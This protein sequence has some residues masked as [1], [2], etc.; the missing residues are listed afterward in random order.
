MATAWIFS[1]LLRVPKY[2]FNHHLSTAVSW[3]LLCLCLC[4]SESLSSQLR[5]CTS[6]VKNDRSLERVQAVSSKNGKLHVIEERQD[7]E[8]HWLRYSLDSLKEIGNSAISFPANDLLLEHFF[9]VNDTLTMVYS[10]WNKTA[11]RTDVFAAR[12]TEFGSLVDSL[13]SVHMRPENGKPRRSGL[14]CELS[15]D[16]TKFVLFFDGEVE[17]KQSEGIHF[18]CFNRSL[19]Q[20]W[21]KELRLPPAVEIAQVHHYL[22]DNSGAIYLMSGRNPIKSFSDWQRPQG[23]QYVAYYFDPYTKRLKQ[24]DI[25]LKDKQ[26]LSTEFA[27][28]D[29]QEV[30]IAG[31]YSNNFKFRVSG[32]LLII[33]NAHG[34]SIKKAAYTPFSEAFITTMEGDGKETLEDFYLDHLHV[35]DSGRVVLVGEQYYVSRF[36]STDPTTGRQMV[37]Y[38]Y[39]FDDVM[40]HCLDTAAEHLWSIRIPKRQFTNSP[41]DVHFSYAFAA[42]ADGY[43]ITFNDDEASTERLL[44]GE[45]TQATLW[46]G[47]KNSVTTLCYVTNT[48]QYSRTTLTDNTSERLLFSPLMTNSGPIG[49]SVFGFSDSRSYK[50]CRRR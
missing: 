37:E 49:H 36:V 22:L 27:L 38:R 6:G 4:F 10:Q 20:L 32:T 16:S 50:F 23:G 7:G 39:N 29:K 5:Y 19:K 9:L 14:Q 12:F 3:A 45:D 25:G 18:R 41:T 47:S 11:E 28:N 30:V 34:G 8:L 17:R 31:Y 21:E 35:G 33:L 1:A 13:H 24:Y 48:G 42:S 2:H 40:M 44:A 43:S 26:V 15:P 46:T